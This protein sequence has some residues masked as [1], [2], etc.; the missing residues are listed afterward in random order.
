MAIPF[1]TDTV[2]VWGRRPQSAQDPD[3]AG[4][5]DVPRPTLGV[6]ASGVRACFSG[7]PGPRQGKETADQTNLRLDPCDVTQ[8]DVVVSDTTGERWRVAA[9]QRHDQ[10]VGGLEHVHC[11]IEADTGLPQTGGDSYDD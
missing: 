1:A 8:F 5:G 11:R 9:V 6:T 10:S 2:T 7:R 4:Y 3:G